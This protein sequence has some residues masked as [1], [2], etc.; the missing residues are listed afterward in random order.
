MS[1]P[2]FETQENFKLFLWDFKRP[3]DEELNK[4]ILETDEN[5]YILETDEEREEWAAAERRAEIR[6]LRRSEHF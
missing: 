1:C 3:S 4:Y 5:K 2:N 6:K